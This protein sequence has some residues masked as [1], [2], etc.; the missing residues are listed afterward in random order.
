MSTEEQALGQHGNFVVQ[1]IA[2]V[3]RNTVG[4]TALGPPSK[5]DPDRPSSSRV[6]SVN[7]TSGQWGWLHYDTAFRFRLAVALPVPDTGKQLMF[8]YNNSVGMMNYAAGPNEIEPGQLKNPASMRAG[9]W[10]D[11]HF[12]GC[13]ANDFF[14]RRNGPGDWTYLSLAEGRALENRSF[15][16]IIGHSENDIYLISDTS[17]SDHPMYHWNGAEL[18]GLD[19]PDEV[20]SSD[21]AKTFVFSSF[22]TAPDGRVFVGS[23]NGHLLMGTAGT[24]FVPVITPEP[25]AP[26]L[27]LKG[28]TWFEDALWAVDGAVLKRLNG[29]EWEEQQFWGDKQRP[30]R[31][32]TITSG[33]DSLLVGSQFGAAMY[34]GG[35]WRKVFGT[36]DP[37]QWL[38]LELLGEGVQDLENLRDSARTLRD[39]SRGA[40]E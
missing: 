3:D 13:G 27:P 14:G 6:L 25:D 7:M 22:A 33:D 28:L 5:D 15:G 32:E 31:F 2:L 34:H 29:T 20:T 19:F 36:G 21:A 17:F 12:Y 1:R 23:T 9:A 4:L 24:G 18:T 35:A 8:W 38:A 11:G 10:I 26:K 30:Y 37:D 40:D 16:H 39:L